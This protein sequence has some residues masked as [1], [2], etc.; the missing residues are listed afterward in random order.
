MKFQDQ[1]FQDRHKESESQSFHIMN[2]LYEKKHI[3][4]FKKTSVETDKSGTDYLVDF[5]DG[6][7]KTVQFKLRKEKYQDIPICRFQPFRGIEWHTV[8]RDYKSLI[9]QKNEYYFVSTQD[10]NL[11]YKS[12]TFTNTSRLVELMIEAEQEW[13]PREDAWTYFNQHLYNN[14]LNKGKF[15]V[16]LKTAKN[17]V[18]AWFRKNKYENFGKIN[19]YIPIKYSDKTI[20]LD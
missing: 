7:F 20:N 5:G 8:G 12:I 2:K 18:Q 13:F 10:N 6:N 19:Y 16:R 15:T 1:T 14:Y 4:A 17:G 3:K 9:Q 11:Q